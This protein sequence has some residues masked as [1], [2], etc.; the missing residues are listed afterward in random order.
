[1]WQPGWEGSLGEDGYMYVYGAEPLHSPPDTVTTLL[2]S[3]TPIQNK[4]FVFFFKKS[5]AHK[6]WEMSTLSW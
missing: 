4:T 5:K 2:I 3:Y 1:M 6:S